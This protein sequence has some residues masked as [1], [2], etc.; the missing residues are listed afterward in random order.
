MSAQRLS[1]V[2]DKDYS[3][4]TRGRSYSRRDLRPLQRK[5]HHGTR[6]VAQ[7]LSPASQNYTIACFEE[8][9]YFLRAK[10]LRN[11]LAIEAIY[12]HSTDERGRRS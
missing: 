9:P 11:L 3:G 8:K 7:G 12:K 1:L 5:P 4:K 6:F 10:L 2:A